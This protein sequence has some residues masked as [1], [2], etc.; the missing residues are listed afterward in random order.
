MTI[1]ALGWGP[2]GKYK[3]MAESH[4]LVLPQKKTVPIALWGNRR[5]QAHP[6][7][8]LRA[9]TEELKPHLD[10]KGA[11]TLVIE[12]SGLNAAWAQYLQKRWFNNSR[13][14]ATIGKIEYNGTIRQIL[15]EIE[16]LL[17]DPDSGLVDKDGKWLDKDSPLR[18]VVSLEVMEDATPPMPEVKL[19]EVP[20][21]EVQKEIEE[22]EVFIYKDEPAPKPP[23]VLTAE[24]LPPALKEE[25]EEIVRDT[26][27]RREAEQE[28]ESVE[29]R[30][31]RAHQAL[32][33]R[34]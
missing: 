34:Q 6:E 13:P 22:V 24:T 15:K 10:K 18:F 27:L 31:K 14:T 3:K 1:Q 21:V 23:E 19:V 16:T 11:L 17:R 5:F 25:V 12:G 7:E 9:M 32:G 28:V 2:D 33:A 29:A 8:N 4:N 26:L 30:A 20:V